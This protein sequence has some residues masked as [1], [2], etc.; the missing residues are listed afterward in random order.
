MERSLV[1]NEPT[2]NNFS[3]WVKYGIPR[4]AEDPVHAVTINLDR[5]Y[6]PDPLVQEDNL[7][8]LI[9]Q[10]VRLEVN[11]V[12]IKP[13]TSQQVNLEP[14]AEVQARSAAEPAR[15]RAGRRARPR[16]G[17]EGCLKR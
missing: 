2:L 14:A 5:I 9:E 11:A 1:G 16:R 7:S 3:Y 12:V 10:L 17:R 13:F 8:R 4:K 15:N 6:H